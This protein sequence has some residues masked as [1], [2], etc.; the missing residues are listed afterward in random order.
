M[1]AARKTN[2]MPPVA[3]A[4]APTA[5]EDHAA[6]VSAQTRTLRNSIVTLAVFFALVIALLLAVPGLRSAAERITDARLPWVGVAVALEL[7]SCAGYVVLFDLVFAKLGPRLVTRLSL[8]ELAMNSVVSASGL[9]GIALGAWVLRSKGLSLEKIAK[10]SVLIFVLT[11][12]VNV[13]AVVVIGVPM[14]LGVLPGTRDP[15]LTLLPAAA[16]LAAIVGTLALAAWARR[17]ASPWRPG[18]RRLAVAL[19]AVSDGV[20]DVVRTIREHDW[21][22]TGAVGYW[23]FDNLA[24]YVCLLAYGP[25]PS[26]WVVAM[27]YLVGML[28]NSLPIPGGFVAVEGGLV[29]MLVLFGARPASLVLAAVVTYRAISLWI[30][31]LIGTFAFLSL[32]REI[33]RPLTTAGS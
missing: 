16:A 23:L 2:S 11:S 32:R 8:A 21:R 12:A 18:A 22:L 26:F 25:S 3:H 14:W 1:Q 27:A 9:A 10:R 7:L 13:G 28:A 5:A 20:A 19:R 30:P 33:G 15:L 24:L 4:A 29:G 31:A 6:A 17:A